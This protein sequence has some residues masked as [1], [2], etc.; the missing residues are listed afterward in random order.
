M[1]LGLGHVAFACAADTNK[2]ATPGT[3]GCTLLR[4][5]FSRTRDRQTPWTNHH[6]KE[7]GW[8]WL[9]HHPC[10]STSKMPKKSTGIGFILFCP[11]FSQR[12]FAKISYKIFRQ[13]IR[14]DT[15][16]KYPE[17]YFAKIF[18]KIFCQNIPPDILP[19]YPPNILPEY[20]AR[21][22]GN[23]LPTYPTRYLAK[24]ATR[25]LRRQSASP[26]WG[27]NQKVSRGDCPG[28]TIVP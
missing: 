5:C 20:P 21:Y 27:P 28:E 1:H 10:F 6:T 11:K 2:L 18:R 26:F 23:I 12:Y 4:H 15:L 13:S 24:I 14:N 8:L 17:R 16:P 25:I 7:G 19:E 3:C 9:N 22:F